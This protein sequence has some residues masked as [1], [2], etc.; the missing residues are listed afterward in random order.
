V[1][2]GRIDFKLDKNANISGGIGKVDFTLE[3]LRENGRA[4]IDAV[5]RA[6]PAAAKGNFLRS[7]TLA[8]T[9]LPGVP[10][11]SAEYIKAATH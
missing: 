1:K 5:V 2:A 11:E 8:A 3:Q 6:K 10:L 4:F 9:M 7:A